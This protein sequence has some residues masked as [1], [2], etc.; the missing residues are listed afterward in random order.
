MYNNE[1]HKACLISGDTN[2]KKLRGYEKNYLVKSSSVGFVFCSKIPSES[3]LIEVYSSKYTREDYLSP[4]TV[5]RYN[6]LLD[7]FD[8]YRKTNKL[9]DVGCGVGNFLE[10]AKKRGWEVFGT[11]YTDKAIQVCQ[12]KGISMHQGVLTSKWFNPEEFDIITS[13]E[14]IEHIN[15]PIEEV[16]NINQLLRKGGLFYFTTPNFN[17]LE[18]FILKADFN[19]ISYPEHL[20]YYT[21]KTIN[22]LLTNN[23]FKKVK[24][25]TTGFSLTRIKTS[26]ELSENRKMTEE[27]VSA[28]STDEKLRVKIES[29]FFL[30]LIKNTLNTVLSFIG[31]GNAI[32][33]WYEKK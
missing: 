27:Y 12:S 13:F 16:N 14:V 28:N 5:L 1:E 18:R 8:K 24:L 31:M 7:Q 20:C 29:N 23:N 33:G 10:L 6:K 11:E 2:I 21:P 32:K 9:L 4:I 22:Y 17:A 25:S 26:I 15:N 19:I 30:K 3:E